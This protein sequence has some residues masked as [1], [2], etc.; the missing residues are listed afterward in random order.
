MKRAGCPGERAQQQRR[1]LASPIPPTW[2]D[3]V[4]A[5]T[6][7]PQ[8]AT[9]P[10]PLPC[11]EICPLSNRAPF[12][13]E[14]GVSSATLS[15]NIVTSEQQ[16]A[17]LQVRKRHFSGQSLLHSALLLPDVKGSSP[18]GKGP[19]SGSGGEGSRGIPGCRRTAPAA[20]P[21]G[22]TFVLPYRAELRGPPPS[23]TIRHQHR[24][25]KCLRLKIHIYRL[26]IQRENWKTPPLS[27]LL[28]NGDQSRAEIFDRSAPLF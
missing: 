26:R 20:L 16:Q 25:G 11:H 18:K 6:G 23:P 9:A 28:R 17:E 4:S 24:D 3:S 5:G 21:P 22:A 1:L 2:P 7:E 10:P 15:A 12:S 14:L 27:R 19:S 8:R 13:C